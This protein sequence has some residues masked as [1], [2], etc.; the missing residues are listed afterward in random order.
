MVVEEAE[1]VV[2]GVPAVSPAST[3]EILGTAS[4]TA[5]LCPSSHAT[6]VR[7]RD[8]SAVSAHREVVAVV[9]EVVVEITS[10]STARRRDT[11]PESVPNLR[12]V[13]AEAEG[14]VVDHAEAEVVHHSEVHHRIRR[15]HLIK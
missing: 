2:K 4:V 11:C 1:V 7:E 15:C 12:V 5:L 9:E 13:D 6:T 8:T 14:D 3:A 10:A